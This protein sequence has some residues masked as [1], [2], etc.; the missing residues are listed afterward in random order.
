MMGSGAETAHE[1]VDAP[2]R[3]R[4]EGRRAEGAAVPAVLAPS[5]SLAALPPTVRSDRRAR[6]H[7]GAG[8]DRRAALPGRR[9]RARRGARR[10]RA[11]RHAAGHR[12]PLRPVVEGVHA[13]DGQGVFDELARAEPETSL[14]RRHRRRRDAH[15]A[16]TYDPRFDIE[17]PDTVARGVLRPRR[18]RHGRRQQELDQD[19]RRGDRRSTPR[20]TS[21][22][23]RRS[24]AR[25]PSRTCASARGRSAR[26]T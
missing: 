24:P 10:R 19:H 20:A 9:H 15:R 18:R 4:R 3:A 6:P 7:Q 11:R 5:A 14:H 1:T 16:S 2:D 22:T 13:G 8:R 23:T 26:P 25:S 12:R 21:S 17:P